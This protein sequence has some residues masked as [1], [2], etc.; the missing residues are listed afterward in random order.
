MTGLHPTQPDA[1]HAV[2]RQPLWE[3]PPALRSE[4]LA[5]CADDG[6]GRTAESDLWCL[7]PDVGGGGGGGAEDAAA[8][9]RCAAADAVAAFEEASKDA[10]DDHGSDAAPPAPPAA[11]A[12]GGAALD[13]ASMADGTDEVDEGRYVSTVSTDDISSAEI[14]ELA[15]ARDLA[16]GG[17]AWRS[18]PPH[19]CPR[20][21]K[22]HYL[23]LVVGQGEH[24]HATQAVFAEV[25]AALAEAVG[26]AMATGAGKADVH[27]ASCTDLRFCVL[28]SPR[29]L[30]VLGTHHL[31]RY[32]AGGADGARL[33]AV[34]ASGWP[35]PDRTALYNF[36]HVGAPSFGS[37]GEAWRV[38]GHYAPHVWDYSL[39][40]VAAL[41]R[42]GVAARHVPLGW[43]ESLAWDDEGAGVPEPEIDVLFYGKLNA[44]RA[45]RL[46][47]LRDAGL[48]VVHANA[49]APH[50]RPLVGRPLDA[51]LRRSKMVLS[52]LYWGHADEWKMTRWLRPLANGVVVLAEASGAPADA[53]A[54][55][56]G[57]VFV[58]G[59]ASA[60][61]EAAQGLARDPGLRARRA[62]AGLALLRGR[63]YA[64][65]VRPAVEA[66][67]GAAGCG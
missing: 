34:I 20:G 65:A 38:L 15:P 50:G 11:A 55:D 14:V 26:T 1:Y 7:V 45:A 67:G 39:A 12:A 46:A 57:V 62:A 13:W 2:A 32:L 44:Y 6:R 54:W 60:L 29:L 30:I 19:P 40:N 23:V 58:A 16:A 18:S 63:A 49:G 33:P 53:E 43:A 21:A 36:E 9:A 4:H 37:D 56:E 8:E 42:R 31:F 59:N 22:P 28:S 47:A 41:R 10:A 52:L 61:V 5:R 35:P 3:L 27:V 64:E 48:A 24:D 66:L 25:A 51:L 17:L